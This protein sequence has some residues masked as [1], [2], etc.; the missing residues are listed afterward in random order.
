MEKIKK[1][2]ENVTKEIKISWNPKTDNDFEEAGF[3]KK[4]ALFC[5]TDRSKSNKADTGALKRRAS[6]NMNF[7]IREILQTY[8][9]C[10]RGATTVGTVSRNTLNSGNYIYS[11]PCSLSTVVTINKNKE[12]KFDE[13]MKLEEVKKILSARYFNQSELN[14]I[15][16]ILD[17]KIAKI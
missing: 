16:K 1:R 3:F 10:K 14:E 9:W 5:F 8:M 13:I 7:L 17:E 12:K 4:A 6:D 11:V 15:I 2:V